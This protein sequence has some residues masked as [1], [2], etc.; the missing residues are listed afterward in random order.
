MGRQLGKQ[1]D[2]PASTNLNNLLWQ[3]ETGT[4]REPTFAQ[5]KAWVSWVKLDAF[6]G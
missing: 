6:R 4:E 5:D 3:M 2:P 1:T